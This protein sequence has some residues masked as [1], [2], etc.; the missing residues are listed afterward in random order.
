MLTN[1][2]AFSMSTDGGFTWSAPVQV[3]QTPTDIAPANQQAF[4]SSIQVAGD[5]AVG[6][7]YYDFRFNDADPGLPTDYWFVHG[8]LNQS[9]VLH[10]GHELRLTEQSFDLEMAPDVGGGLLNTGGLFLGDYAGLA[11]S[12]SNFMS[13]FARPF[14]SNPANIF[15]RAI[16][17]RTAGAS[18]GEPV[19]L[20]LPTAGIPANTVHVRRETPRDA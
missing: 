18:D 12:G 2:I 1:S 6:V 5:G 11:A 9:G 15:Y 7:T 17:R 16:G 8:R 4:V 20:V 14:E 3:N 19:S 13:F 10:W